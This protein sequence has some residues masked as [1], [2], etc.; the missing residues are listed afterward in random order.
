[1]NISTLP[2]GRRY[3]VLDEKKRV[4]MAGEE[5]PAGRKDLK[6]D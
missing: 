6:D 3:C 1:M 2:S 4:F 5:K